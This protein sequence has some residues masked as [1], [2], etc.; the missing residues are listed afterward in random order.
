MMHGTLLGYTI[1]WFLFV[2]RTTC[3]VTNC[4][5]PVIYPLV[6]CDIPLQ[7][8]IPASRVACYTTL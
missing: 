2:A 3:T 8:R 4:I 7:P 5:T 1:A 6:S